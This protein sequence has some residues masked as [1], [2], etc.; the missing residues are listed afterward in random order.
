MT[1]HVSQCTR[2][3]TPPATPVKRDKI[4]EIVSVLCCTK[5]K[6]PFQLL[7]NGRM[8]FRPWNSLRPHRTV[9]PVIDSMYI[10]DQS[11]LKP[12]SHRTHALTRCALVTHLRDHLVF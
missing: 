12:F 5:P 10:A 9:C 7:W 3:K 2:S 8:L 4:I 11:R 1:G 6:I